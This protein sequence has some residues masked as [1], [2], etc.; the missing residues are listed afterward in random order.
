[1]NFEAHMSSKRTLAL[2]KEVAEAGMIEEIDGFLRQKAW[3]GVLKSTLTQRQLKK[4]LRSSM[5][6]K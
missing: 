5:F 3:T 1:M 4:I 6:I 2:Y